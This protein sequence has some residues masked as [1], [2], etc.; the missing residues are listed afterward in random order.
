MSQMSPIES[1]CYIPSEPPRHFVLVAKF[2]PPSLDARE[3]FLLDEVTPRLDSLKRKGVISRWAFL[4]EQ[5][6]EIFVK[7][8]R[9]IDA[10][11]LEVELEKI[12]DEKVVSTYDLR[13]EAR[14]Q[15]RPLQVHRYGD[16]TGIR[17][18]DLFLWQASKMA[19]RL[20]E[21]TEVAEPLELGLASI[22]F[23]LDTLEVPDSSK[24]DAMN[25]WI[26]DL[27]SIRNTGRDILQPDPAY[28][29]RVRSAFETMK[30]NAPLESLVQKLV[31]HGWRATPTPD[32]KDVLLQ[33]ERQMRVIGRLLT[34][35]KTE[36]RFPV[37]FPW[38][39]AIFCNY[40]HFHLFNIGSFGTKEL[41]LYWLIVSAKDK[42]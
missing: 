34:R 26:D 39:R 27:A 4:F 13:W 31:A 41:Y 10:A 28:G 15:I 8:R 29:E 6:I 12:F 24:F 14:S 2:N 25:D 18:M 7:V 23:L 40:I 21:L 42:R 11:A 32:I 19:R 30:L 20:W 16:L 9:F 22:F 1:R 37:M 35:Q 33:Y 38:R 36:A 3:L 5:N 17:T